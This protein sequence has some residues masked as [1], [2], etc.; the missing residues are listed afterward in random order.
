MKRAAWVNA[1]GHGAWVAGLATLMSGC[2]GGGASVSSDGAAGT[3]SQV[4]PGIAEYLT[5][6][7]AALPAYSTAAFPVHFDAE[8][9]RTQDNTPRG[10][11]ITDK[12]ASL[13]RVLFHDKRLSVNDT[14]ACASCHLQPLGMGDSAPFSAGF[15]P[16]LVTGAHS[17]RLGNSRFY[18]AGSM[19]WDK[20]A[21]SLESQTTQP[22][23]S[24]VEMG[25]DASHGGLPALLAK[26]KSL[27]YYP[28]LFAT[29]FGD[30]SITE[31][32]IQLAL[33][34]FVRS[35]ASTHSRWDEGA[36]LVYNPAAPNKGLGAPLP[37]FTAA[38]NRGQQLF[39]APPNQGGAGCVV[40]HQAPTFALNSNSRSNGLEAGE[41]RI[42]KAP[43]LK[44][45]ST[46]GPFMHNASLATLEEVVEHYNSGIQDG[47]ALDPRLRRPDGQPL[48][49]NLSEGDK[50]ALVAFL[51]T[52]Q[53]PVL[54]TDPKF[55]SP[56]RK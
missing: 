37:N 50:A 39:F 47:P 35:M 42:F 46:A 53:D 25:F 49:L 32:R 18:A 55:A 19:F 28:E 20:R 17:M 29:V 30:P 44:N 45:V 10:N 1:V 4:D 51:K 54:N 2:G 41:S 14:L 9:F 12:G 31:E 11:P 43:S 48:R 15:L 23:Q 6:D 7:L 52:L 34:Q 36:A 21:A 27:P 5:L 33:A 26:M 38:E 13:G 8:V 16:G 22:I 40:C 3:P 56:F 24:P